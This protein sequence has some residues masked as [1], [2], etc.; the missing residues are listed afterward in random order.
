MFLVHLCSSGSLI[1]TWQAGKNYLLCKTTINTK[2]TTSFGG[3]L[4]NFGGW[5]WSL[6]QNYLI[7]S[8]PCVDFHSYSAKYGFVFD[9]CS[10]KTFVCSRIILLVFLL[11]KRRANATQFGYRVHL[12]KSRIQTKIVFLLYWVSSCRFMLSQASCL[13]SLGPKSCLER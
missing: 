4:R 12:V 13:S 11:C 3:D 7:L 5:Q 2:F 9:S 8:A 10:T 1:V 6:L